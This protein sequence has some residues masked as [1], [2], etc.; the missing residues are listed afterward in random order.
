MPST[1]KLGRWWCWPF[2]IRLSKINWKYP[3]Q[4][5]PQAHLCNIVPKLKLL[6][7][8]I[9]L[10]IKLTIKMY[11]YMIRANT[12]CFLKSRGNTECLWPA[13]KGI[14]VPP[15]ALGAILNQSTKRVK[16]WWG[17]L[18]ASLTEKLSM[19]LWIKVGLVLPQ[20]Q[21]F[22]PGFKMCNGFS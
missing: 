1:P 22:H 6:L 21:I 19:K 8:R 18:T 20:A 15:W 16:N 12:L 9:W 2:W 4:T 13:I 7:P 17:I 14:Y 10:C 11:Q 3:S 5:W